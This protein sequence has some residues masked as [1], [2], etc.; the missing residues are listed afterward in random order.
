MSAPLSGFGGKRLASTRGSALIEA[1]L[2]LPLLLLLVMNGMNFGLFLYGWITV[3]NA[4]R[5]A[6]QYKVYNGVVL[7]SNDDPPTTAQVTSNVLTGE[8]STL[9]NS[10]SVSIEICSRYNSVT[11]P[12]TCSFTPQDDPEPTRFTA[13]TIKV[14]YTYQPYFTA[15]TAINSSQTIQ[16]S[17]VLRS[18]Q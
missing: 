6:A 4:A 13:W 14:S 12:S 15:L 5:A 16:Q 9:P 1:A 2:V 18:M 17:V 7:G 10:G 8:T 3:N 11:S